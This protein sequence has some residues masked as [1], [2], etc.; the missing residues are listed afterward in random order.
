M[1]ITWSVS[2]RRPPSGGGRRSRPAVG[3]V[4]VDG[5]GVV[6]RRGGTWRSNCAQAA[7]HRG[8]LPVAAALHRLARRR[9]ATPCAAP[10]RARTA[11]RPGRPRGGRRGGRTPVPARGGPVR[12]RRRTPVARPHP[13]TPPIA[14]VTFSRTATTSC[15][16]QSR[17]TGASPRWTPSATRCC[18]VTDCCSNDRPRR[19]ERHPPH[20]AVRRVG[21]P[22]HGASAL[23]RVDVHADARPAEPDPP[24]QLHLRLRSDARRAHR[25][26]Q[27]RSA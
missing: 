13:G 16:S 18:T 10:R 15:A 4:A 1:Y 24:S 5:D 21:R 22:L 8:D 2:A 25:A 9:R 27:P 26:P 20:P 11:R 19:V 17:S 14:G 23:E 7:D 12:R 6:G 3:I